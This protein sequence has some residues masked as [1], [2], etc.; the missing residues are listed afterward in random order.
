MTNTSIDGAVFPRMASIPPSSRIVIGGIETHKHL[1]VAA[2]LDST[3]VV[4][5]C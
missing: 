4:R 2:V 3:G 1:H 5:G